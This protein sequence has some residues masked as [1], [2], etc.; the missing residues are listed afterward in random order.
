MSRRRRHR[1]KL[2]SLYVWH[3][4]V[5]LVAALFVIV[6]AGTGLA[7]NHTEALELDS[8]HVRSAW[9]LDWYGISLPDTVPA[10]HAGDHWISQWERHLYLDSRDLGEHPEGRLHGAVADGDWLIVALEHALLL[11]TADG[12]LVEKLPQSE[13]P[14]GLRGVA[15][16]HGRPVLITS[17]GHFM[18]DDDL[19]SWQPLPDA[20]VSPVAPAALPAELSE[21]IAGQWRGNGL[22]LERVLLDV[23]SGRILGQAGVYLMDAAAALL[24]FLSLSGGGIWIVRSVRNRRRG[25]HSPK[26][27]H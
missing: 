18:S 13:L 7:L 2:K 14:G 9:L 24:L 5:G 12:Q 8:R 22:T 19:V 25:Q 16:V 3:R 21:G 26:T 23:H 6:L 10:W 20:A 27:R 4:W 11:L 15:L 1:L 17:A